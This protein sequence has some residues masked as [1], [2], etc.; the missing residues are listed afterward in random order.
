MTKIKKTAA[1]LAAINAARLA[2]RQKL[3]F[4]PEEVERRKRALKSRKEA[5]VQG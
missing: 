4:A 5:D 2:M 3:W 1:E